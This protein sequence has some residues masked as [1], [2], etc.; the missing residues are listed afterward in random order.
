MATGMA[1]SWKPI[2]V[3]S[4][5]ATQMPPSS[6]ASTSRLTRSVAANGTMNA[7]KPKRLRT[8]SM[9]VW[10]LTIEKRPDISTRKMTQIVPSNTAQR[11]ESPNAAPAWAE[12]AIEPT[13]RKPPMLVTMPSAMPRIFF[14]GPRSRR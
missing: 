14:I 6:A 12:V 11:S 9:M 4:W 7:A 5:S 8:A 1:H 3:R 10:P 13:S 2:P